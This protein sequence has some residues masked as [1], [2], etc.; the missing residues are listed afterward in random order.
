MVSLTFGVDDWDVEVQ[1]YAE[2]VIVSAQTETPYGVR[3]SYTPLIVTD[4]HEYITIDNIRDTIAR[5]E[6]LAGGLT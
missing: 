3:T 6:A 2:T 1:S 5:R 4:E